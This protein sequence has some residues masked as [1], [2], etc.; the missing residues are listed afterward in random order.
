M[1]HLTPG[2]IYTFKL[3]SG[4]EI[5]AKIFKNTDGIFEVTQ[6]ISMVL[7]PQGLQMMPSLFSSNPEKNV[8]INT[9][10]IAMAAETREDVRAKYIEATTGIVTPPAKQIITG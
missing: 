9:V 3:V 2:E 7:G 4:E 6:P 10:N 1:N 5:T 8:Y